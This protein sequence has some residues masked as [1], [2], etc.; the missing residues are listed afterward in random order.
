MEY[1]L[2]DY[3]ADL[4][5]QA[6]VNGAT[7]VIDGFQIGYA[8]NP[9]VSGSIVS[10]VN[11][12]YISDET[13]Q[14]NVQLS[15]D[16]NVLGISC[17]LPVNADDDFDIG[18]VLLTSSSVLYNIDTSKK[19]NQIIVTPGVKLSSYTAGYYILVQVANSN[20]NVG[21]TVIT[22]SID[23]IN[24]IGSP[25]SIIINP[26][27]PILALTIGYNVLVNIANTNTKSNCTVSIYGLPNVYP[28]VDINGY[29]LAPGVLQ[30]DS[31]CEFIFTGTSFQ[32]SGN[33]SIEVTN[34]DFTSL[35]PGSLI[36]GQVYK[37][38]CIY[39]TTINSISGKPCNTYS[40]TPEL[41]SFLTPT[42][43]AFGALGKAVVKTTNK[44]TIWGTLS[45]STTDISTQANQITV[46]PG[47]KL[48]NLVIGY[49]AIVKVANT[50]TGVTTL[51]FSNGEI[52]D[53]GTVNALLVNPTHP[54]ASLST[55]S[56]PY[57]LV[58]K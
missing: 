39:N 28:I 38:T 32:L 18:N 57:P 42:P 58:Y 2:L 33:T 37:L 56:F 52:Q 22:F 10:P 1:T 14:L 29:P 44:L 41:Y 21:K 49:T 11:P 20:N 43:F 7:I 6:I 16:P 47:I 12:V 25:N 35:A 3:G 34:A 23:S 53:I 13:S 55:E 19:A 17:V 24:D 5:N 15:Y 54:V 50:N 51:T 4:V 31:I 27:I 40:F 8:V 26:P 9:S 45:N 36:A 30:K 46:L 48:S